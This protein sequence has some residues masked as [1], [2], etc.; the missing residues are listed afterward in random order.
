MP[1]GFRWLYVAAAAVITLAVLSV[2]YSSYEKVGVKRPLLSELSAHSDVAGA[3]V[4]REGP[5]TVVDIDLEK[6]PDLAVTYRALDEIVERHMGTAAY[7]IRLEDAGSPGLDAAY[8]LI[9]FYVEEAAVRGT[10]GEMISESSKR[11]EE[12]GY[13]D[14]KI[15]VDKDRIYV[16]ISDSSGYL[17]RIVDR[18]PVKGGAGP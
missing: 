1:R 16:Q 6:V 15:S 14:Y 9:H 18:E 3:D 7:R 10:F 12:A 11:L 17:Y 5:E 4:R 2:S 8:H 13:N